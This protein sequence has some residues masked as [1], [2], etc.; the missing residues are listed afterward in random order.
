MIKTSFRFVVRMTLGDKSLAL[1][2]PDQGT[3]K[4]DYI[5]RVSRW[6]FWRKYKAVKPSR[7]KTTAA[8]ALGKI[9][10]IPAEDSAKRYNYVPT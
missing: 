3:A 2:H 1:K 6:L 7:F 8:R 4:G 9:F 10:G 5:T